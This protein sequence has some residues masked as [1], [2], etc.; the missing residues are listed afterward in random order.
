MPTSGATGD[1]PAVLPV[2][3]AHNDEV[4][5]CLTIVDA[6][7]VERCVAAGEGGQVDMAVG[8]S[9]DPRFHEAVG[10]RGNVRRVGQGIPALRGSVW[11]GMSIEVGRWAVVAAGGISVWVTEAAAPTWDLESWRAVGLEPA[12]MDVIVVRSAA[13]WRASFAR[14]VGE[15][16]FLDLPGASTPRLDRLRFSRVVHPLYPVSSS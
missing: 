15:A 8:C 11:G 6:A 16:F 4:Q 10:L 1:S 9:M 7:A 12:R 3:L 14:L 13:L 5:G 2:L